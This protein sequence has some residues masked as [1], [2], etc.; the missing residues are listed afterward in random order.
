MSIRVTAEIPPVF[1]WTRTFFLGPNKTHGRHPVRSTSD[2]VLPVTESENPDYGSLHRT[3]PAYVCR[4]GRVGVY[5]HSPTHGRPKDSL[6]FYT[7]GRTEEGEHLYSPVKGR[8]SGW[9]PGVQSSGCPDDRPRKT[10]VVSGRCFGLSRFPGRSLGGWGHGPR[11]RDTSEVEGPPPRGPRQGSSDP[12][13]RLPVGVPPLDEV[14]DT[15]R[16]SG[17]VWS[18]GLR[19]IHFTALSYPLSPHP[20]SV[21]GRP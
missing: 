16:D 4:T 17:H 15:S 10:G 14:V 8:V 9:A 6:T 1:G 20:S 7:G 21:P 13:L 18:S 2:N 19:V 12:G 5:V 3:G 11:A